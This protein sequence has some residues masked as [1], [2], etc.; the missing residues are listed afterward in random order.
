MNSANS[1]LLIWTKT[2]IPS[3]CQWLDI[4]FN[5]GC[6]SRFGDRQEAAVIKF[7]DMPLKISSSE[8]GED[9]AVCELWL[10]PRGNLIWGIYCNKLIWSFEG[11]ISDSNT[12]FV[13][14][15]TSWCSEAASCEID[16]THTSKNPQKSWTRHV[17]SQGRHTN[18]AFFF[19][20][21]P[22]VVVIM[23][24]SSQL[25]HMMPYFC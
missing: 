5:T 17:I 11:N 1:V 2:V 16:L 18:R 4:F 8:S 15:S 21:T 13:L 6:E 19:W 12:S 7:Q 20:S 22:S 24:F 14:S 9:A 23:A 10:P 25:L 3:S